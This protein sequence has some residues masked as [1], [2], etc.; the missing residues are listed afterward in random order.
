MKPEWRIG[1]II[2]LQ[3]AW[4]NFFTSALLM[5]S[6]SDSKSEKSNDKQIAQKALLPEFLREGNKQE[7]IPDIVLESA[8]LGKYIQLKMQEQGILKLYG[9]IKLRIRERILYADQITI[10]MD[11]GEIFAPG[12]VKI[13]EKS[14]FIFGKDFYYSRKQNQAIFYEIKAFFKPFYFDGSLARKVNDELTIVEKGKL[15][16][17]D[18]DCPHYYYQV[19]KIWVYADRKIFAT[20]IWMYVGNSPI[21]YFPFIYQTREG[22]GIITQFG[23]TDRRGAYIQNTVNLSFKI[24]KITSLSIGNATE[25]DTKAGNSQEILHS[26][27]MVDYYQRMG[28][29]FALWTNV[30]SGILKFDNRI[31]IANHYPVDYD[32]NLVRFKNITESSD[33][34]QS[35]HDQEGGRLLNLDSQQWVSLISKLDYNF[36][37]DPLGA[38]SISYDV[39]WYSHAYMYPF[40]EKR[41]EPDSTAMMLQSLFVPQSWNTPIQSLKWYGSYQHKGVNTHF[42]VY[43]QR[44]WQWDQSKTF[45]DKDASY[46]PKDEI[47]PALQYQ[48][49]DQVAFDKG[50]YFKALYNIGASWNHQKNY[51]IYGNKFQE[52]WQANGQADLS[53]PMSFFRQLMLLN[54]KLSYGLKMQENID[55]TESQKLEANRNSYHFA[56][57]GMQAKWGPADYNFQ[58]EYQL[59]RTFAEGLVE[60]PFYSY[61]KHQLSYTLMVAPLQDFYLTASGAYDLRDGYYREEDKWQDLVI[62]GHWILNF[63]NFNNPVM[64]DFYKKYRLIFSRIHF[65]NNYNYI[66]KTQKH[67]I[68]DL[69]MKY[70]LGNFYSS[71]IDH[72]ELF[73][74]GLRWYHDFQNRFRDRIFATWETKVRFFQHWKLTAGGNSILEQVYRYLNKDVAPST[75]IIQSLNLFSADER[76]QALFR[77]QKI[78]AELSHDLHCWEMTFGWSM[79]HNLQPFGLNLNHRLSFYEHVVYFSFRSKDLQDVGIPQSDIYRRKPDPDA[80]Q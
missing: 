51:D 60:A 20:D 36:M 38:H 33:Y 31:G 40:F 24:P 1:W 29:Y 41:F 25:K 65:I 69:S 67:G 22:S 43:L 9:R 19:K 70:E 23:Y 28:Q 39:T 42:L 63:I 37:V 66:L 27:W 35:V 32:A 50:G 80:Y 17:C 12:L 58:I 59:Q 14:S 52:M 10:N 26:K 68:N 18:L 30:K 4:I 56:E 6:N 7:I 78:Y 3:L 46:L 79:V 53:L 57:V 47:V 16:T 48:W 62:K 54:P 13:E 45:L 71:W 73:S 76:S 8:D 49:H 74:F 11:S 64:I 5:A 72:W 61:R 77:V 55:P 21:F 44:Y 34:R 15:T 75:D 2:L